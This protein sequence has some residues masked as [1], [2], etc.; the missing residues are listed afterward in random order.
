[1]LE[2]LF[3]TPTTRTGM[4]PHGQRQPSGSAV[5]SPVL[6]DGAARAAV[7]PVNP[8]VGRRPGV[9]RPFVIRQGLIYAAGMVA[10]N[11]LGAIVT[12]VYA[13]EVIPRVPGSGGMA[14]QT[15]LNLLVFPA[16]LV[17]ALLIGLGWSVFRFRTTVTWL[18]ADRY[19]TPPERR[20]ALRQPRRQ[21]VVHATLWAAGVVL[22]LVLN[23]SY[24]WS[25]ARDAALATALGGMA[26]CALGYLLAERL[27]RPVTTM[28]LALEGPEPPTGPG[29]M[30]R[31][32]LAWAFGTGVPL[33]GAALAVWIR[34]NPDRIARDGPVLFLVGAG[35]LVGLASMLLL[36]RSIATPI[37][38][39]RRAV[40]AV[41][42][43]DTDIEVPVFDAGEIGQLQHAV[44]EMVRALRE[45]TRIRDIFGR[46]V[47]TDIA[48]DVL[49]RGIKLG[50]ETRDVAV[51]FV[52]LDGS[53]AFAATHPP[54][55]VVDLLNTFFTVVVDVVA[56]HGGV[57]NKFDGDGALCIFGAPIDQ[58]QAATAALAAGRA[59][60]DRIA[61][62]DHDHIHVGIGISAGPV[63][64]GN[65][66][67]ESRFEYTVIGDPVNEAS[68]LTDLA[69]TRTERLL[70]AETVL[71][72]ADPTETARWRTQESIIL[73]GRTEPTRL[74]TSG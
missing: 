65:V 30:T 53:T 71:K 33:L 56:D 67:A 2:N 24:S 48:R 38:S 51:L 8:A 73:T 41:E 62:L 66:G 22:F 7:G 60:R 26:T 45:A 57:V 37:A 36:A 70:A 40:Q 23:A 15:R 13:A 72:Q 3:S 11:T 69:K 55:E 32:A 9:G 4:S 31:I 58:P 6:P 34:G 47:G 50:G 17:V 12:F 21:L 16:Y 14:A 1:M 74:A 39:V 28:A 43:G 29:V 25:V 5:A 20:T 42:A 52:D 64:T 44:N 63:V 27:L 59:L 49:S 68:R 35:L 19:P 61:S 18:L 46:Q 54:A 10:A